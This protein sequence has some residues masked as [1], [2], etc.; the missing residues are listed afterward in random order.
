MNTSHLIPAGTVV[1]FG[2]LGYIIHQK[3]AKKSRSLSAAI[4]NVQQLNIFPIKSCQGIPLDEAEV[5][6]TG[7]TNDRRWMI[8]D[9]GTRRFLTQRQH[10]KMVLI[11]SSFK[12]N[13]QD[14]PHQYEGEKRRIPSWSKDKGFLCLDAPG[15]TDIFIPINSS[16]QGIHTSPK[17]INYSY[18]FKPKV[19]SR[20]TIKSK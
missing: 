8:V 16:E 1:F 14:K 18:F 11:R 19:Q 20:C 9:A 7:F 13:D 3:A 6:R 17:L 12:L 4:G 5:G 2:I 15:M 10:P